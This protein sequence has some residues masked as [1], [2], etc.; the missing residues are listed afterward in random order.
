MTE[1]VR[2]TDDMKLT[3]AKEVSQCLGYMKTADSM[4]V[5]WTKI[6]DSISKKPAF[7]GLPLF[8]WGSLKKMFDRWSEQ[9]LKTYGV[10]EEGSN[11]S[12]LPEQPSEFE[13]LI[14]NMAQAKDESIKKKKIEKE[15]TQKKQQSLF[16]HEVSGL[17]KQGMMKEWTS[18]TNSTPVECNNDENDDYCVSVNESF[19][20][21]STC[22]SK[23]NK[24]KH[25]RDSLLNFEDQIIDL[26]NSHTTTATNQEDIQLER[27]EKRFLIEN[28]T[29]NIKFQA[30]S[31]NS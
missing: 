28:M 17:K 3:L 21:D 23:I 19:S 1:K 9:M 22:E 14:L 10:S 13:L 4:E 11:L 29:Q 18:K 12:G 31:I 25:F 27:D 16:G 15:N 5:K 7:E 8:Q 2:W 30:N 26:C 24:R 6:S 20:S